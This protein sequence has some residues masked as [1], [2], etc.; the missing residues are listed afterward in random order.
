LFLAF[1]PALRTKLV[2]PQEI[3]RAIR[4]TQK[5]KSLDSNSNSCYKRIELLSSEKSWC[6]SLALTQ[7]SEPT[8]SQDHN[9]P[10]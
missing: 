9:I 3:A 1:L 7:Q 10:Q 6:S 2:R 8:P 4:I 5:V